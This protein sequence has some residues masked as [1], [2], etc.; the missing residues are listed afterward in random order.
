[1][2]HNPNPQNHPQQ[3][4]QQ[5][6]YPPKKPWYKRA[7]IMIPL[8]ILA[9]FVLFMG[10]C[11]ALFGSAANEVD[12]KMNEEHAVTYKITGDAN[13]ATASYTANNTNTTQDTGVA[14][15]WEKDV[16]L[17]GFSLAT[18]TAT[19]GMNDTGSITCQIIVDG[20]VVNENTASGEFATASCSV[21]SNE[22]D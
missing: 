15:G 6:I 17:K 18:L 12:K 21:D 2:P 7:I 8:T 9:I 22:L 5:P 19:N 14:A 13:D 4:W 3:Q 16:T 11:M 20:Q 10:G 1:M